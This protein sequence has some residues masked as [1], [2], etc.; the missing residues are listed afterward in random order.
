MEIPGRV[1]FQTRGKQCKK[2]HLKLTLKRLEDLGSR[3]AWQCVEWDILLETG[4]RGNGMRNCWISNY[5][6]V[7]YYVEKVGRKW[8]ALSSP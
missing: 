7:N 8:A 5:K 6:R 4:G 3:N 1:S 2:N